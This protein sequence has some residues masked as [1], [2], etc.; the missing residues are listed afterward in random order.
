MNKQP[1]TND[2]PTFQEIIK[3]KSEDLQSM[4]AKFAKSTE[5]L[6][7][8]I[9]TSNSAYSEV[10]TDLKGTYAANE[11]YFSTITKF[12]SDK[13]NELLASQTA[14][15]E[16]KSQTDEV[17]KT[18]ASEIK[19][20]FDENTKLTQQNITLSETITKLQTR[21][22]AIQPEINKIQKK[23]NE[24]LVLQRTKDQQIKK[25]SENYD[26]MD[27][28]LRKMNERN[29]ALAH[30]NNAHSKRLNYIWKTI[31]TLTQQDAINEH[32]DIQIP[33]THHTS[34]SEEEEDSDDTR[35][36]NIKVESE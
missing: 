36:D 18:N 32:F 20:L 10:L 33:V 7:S 22:N 8:S 23:N 35:E 11:E 9:S 29:S 1:T 21:N 14:V 12:Q 30:S 2:E 31:L 24:L 6:N 34:S 25:C 27:G 26:E 15:G 3:K 13:I 17:M 5:T 16:D 28:K 4:K 19:R